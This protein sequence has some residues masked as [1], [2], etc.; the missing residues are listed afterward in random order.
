MQPFIHLLLVDD[1]DEDY[2][3][4]EHHLSRVKHSNYHLHG[5]DDLASA[6]SYLQN[7]TVDLVLVDYYLASQ[8]GVE[9]I[10]AAHQAGLNLPFIVL[11]GQDNYESDREAL[12]SGAADYLN[13]NHLNPQT[14]DRSIR[15]ALREHQNLQRI[16]QSE[17]QLRE[18]T[19]ELEKRVEE[20]THELDKAR[21]KAESA[22]LAKS[23]FLA[24]MSHEIRTPLNAILGFSQ[25]LQRDQHLEPKHQ[26]QLGVIMQSG[27]HLLALINDILEMSKI[28]AGRT[29]LN[30]QPGNIH[31]LLEE[32]SS[33]FEVRAKE[34]KIQF[35]IESPSLPTLIFDLQK[36]R[37]VL[38]NLVSNAIKFTEQGTVQ[39]QV[40]QLEHQQDSCHLRFSVKDTG[41][42]I[43]ASEAHQVF[44]PFEQTQSGQNKSMGTGLGLAISQQFIKLM[45]SEIHFESQL[46]QGCHFHFDLRLPNYSG[47][48]IKP[49]NLNAPKLSDFKPCSVLIVDDQEINR[50]LLQEMLQI[51]GFETREAESGMIAL[52][53]FKQ[54][55]SEIIFMDIRMPEMDGIHCVKKIRELPTGKDVRIIMCSAQVFEDDQEE[56]F[57]AGADDFL[58]K[59]FRVSD[60]CTLLQKYLPLNTVIF[61]TKQ[62]ESPVSPPPLAS[63]HV[64]IPADLLHKMSEA[65]VCGDQEQVLIYLEQ[66]RSSHPYQV[67][68]WQKMAQD[69]AYEELIAELE[70]HQVKDNDQ[71]SRS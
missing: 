24:N 13:K 68:V 18:L 4:T 41:L 23:I 48:V 32:L 59:P 55:P 50:N 26:Q 44:Q 5:C 63:V 40:Q 45:D 20:R 57:Q 53:L 52:E 69:Y 47:D 9:L 65:L 7:E 54:A 15:Y 22:N 27:E 58:A 38:L 62:E 31:D 28:E 3:I 10:Q 29:Q 42:G 1:D 25:L 37:Q 2:V 12:S 60:L 35:L 71:A 67:E 51:H 46:G 21:Q 49:E 16:S 17:Q 30:P 56:A 11:T 33:V 6:L 66:V 19:Y 61:E 70:A 34:K 64:A 36:L 14:L 8:T 39:V 43:D